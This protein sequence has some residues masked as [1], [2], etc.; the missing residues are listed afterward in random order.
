MISAIVC[1]S[2]A[3][4][5]LDD[6]VVNA[7]LTHR[8]SRDLPGVSAAVVR[9]DGLAWAGAVG[10]ADL[11]TGSPLS[12]DTPLYA[13]SLSKVFT[14]VLA[15]NM[16]EGGELALDSRPAFRS[17]ADR[18][19][20]HTLLTHTSGLP[21]EGDFDYWF[22]GEFPGRDELMAYLGD[23]ALRSQP[24]DRQRYSNI[25]YATLGLMLERRTRKSFVQLLQERVLTPLDL[26]ASGAPGPVAGL[27]RGYTPPDR[28]LPG[29]DRKFAGVGAPAGDRRLRE[30]HDAG[31]MTPAFGV[32][33]SARDLGVLALF[34]LG[35]GGEDI[36]SIDM[37]QRMLSRQVSD[38]GLGL[39]VEVVDGHTVARHSGW[40]A[41][42]RSHLLLDAEAG[43]A[44][45]VMTNSDDG[46]PGIL[47]ESLLGIARAA[48]P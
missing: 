21:R 42:H 43:I 35:T 26:S 14:A 7:L 39:G 46:A 44:V 11:E 40:F 37:R 17:A 38:R 27:A 20:V 16:V 48:G 45:V 32:Y 30:Y 29:G 36:L 33:S 1:L 3:A 9:D 12:A 24:G 22:S 15:L 28:T 6:R 10:V 4:L 2:I 5:P 13:G 18:A 25:G 41:A 19:T 34:L 8:A 23:V 31:A 47:A